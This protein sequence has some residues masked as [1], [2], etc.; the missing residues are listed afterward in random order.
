[1]VVQSP[2]L[3]NRLTPVANIAQKFGEIMVVRR[4]KWVTNA[5]YQRRGNLLRNDRG[6]AD[7]ATFM[8][9]S[10]SAEIEIYEFIKW[11]YNPR[12]GHSALF[13]EPLINSP[14]AF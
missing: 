5:A 7:M 4:L 11:F 6:K 9:N 10:G 13:R 3:S 8:A 2:A 14:L 1:V 12:R